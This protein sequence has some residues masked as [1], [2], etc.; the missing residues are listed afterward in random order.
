T[1]RQATAQPQPTSRYAP[2]G[3]IPA[4][5]RAPASRRF[6]RGGRGGSLSRACS[7]LSYSEN[8]RSV[9]V[10]TMNR[11]TSRRSPASRNSVPPPGGRTD[12]DQGMHPFDAERRGS[13]HIRDQHQ[14]A[15]GQQA[16]QP[17]A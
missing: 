10:Q 3:A 2:P 9:P 5:T 15:I 6:A 7:T 4:S 17:V 8:I 13:R 12:Q 16:D 1:E 14:D 11:R